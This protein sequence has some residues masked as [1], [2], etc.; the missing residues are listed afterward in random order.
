MYLL[1]FQRSTQQDNYVSKSV[2]NIYTNTGGINSF[3]RSINFKKFMGENTEQVS[4]CN[5]ILK[6]TKTNKLKLPT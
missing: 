5:A 4:K 3:Y 6:T 1:T 2:C